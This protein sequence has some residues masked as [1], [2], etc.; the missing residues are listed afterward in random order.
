MPDPNDKLF[1]NILFTNMFFQLRAKSSERRALTEKDHK[2]IAKLVKLQQSLIAGEHVQNRTLQNN[3]TSAQYEEFSISW[4]REKQYREDHFGK[5]PEAI[6]EY[7]GLLRKADFA[8][9]RGDAYSRKGNRKEAADF[10]YKAEHLYERAIERLS[11]LLSADPTIQTWLDRDFDAGVSLSPSSVPR[12]RTSRG[13]NNQS[14]LS[15]TK[16]KDLKIDAVEK[17]IFELIY[18]QEGS[19]KPSAKLDSILKRLDSDDSSEFDID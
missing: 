15:K 2:R 11:E 1:A 19:H 10:L 18:D 6:A 3:L 14:P 17:A 9:N 5:K 4:D 13:V 8:F 16:I 7:E 12:A